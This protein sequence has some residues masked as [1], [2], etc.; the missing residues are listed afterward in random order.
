MPE[1]DAEPGLIDGAENGWMMMFIRARSRSHAAGSARGATASRRVVA[2]DVGWSAWTTSRVSMLGDASQ[3]T[4]I[5]GF[6]S[7]RNSSIHSGWLSITATVATRNSR[8]SS[9]RPIEKP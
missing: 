6:S 8:S 9:S 1:F 2:V 3:R 7:G 5:V 4:A